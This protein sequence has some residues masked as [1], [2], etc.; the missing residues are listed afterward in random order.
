M[1]VGAAS[2]RSG[3]KPRVGRHDLPT[4]RVEAEILMIY[5]EGRPNKGLPLGISRAERVQ[6][7]C[8][9]DL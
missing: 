5:N 3:K 1:K 8:R 7:Y 9:P 6:Q 4:A 2:N